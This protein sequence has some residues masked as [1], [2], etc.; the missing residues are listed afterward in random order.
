MRRTGRSTVFVIVLTG[1]WTI[2]HVSG[3][4]EPNVV[5]LGDLKSGKPTIAVT[6]TGPR[7]AWSEK[8]GKKTVML[9]DGIAGDEFDDV[10]PTAEFSRTGHVAYAA[11][12]DKNWIIVIDG[13]EDPLTTNGAGFFRF[14]EDGEHFGY[15]TLE[16]KTYTWN[17]DH[18]PVLPAFA[19]IPRGFVSAFRQIAASPNLDR[20]AFVEFRSNDLR[21]NDAVIS[22]GIGP[23]LETTNRRLSGDFETRAEFIFVCGTKPH[24][25]I[26][27][28][29]MG[30]KGGDKY[31][32]VLDGVAGELA[33]LIHSPRCNKDGSTIG[34]VAMTDR[35][36]VTLVGLINDVGKAAVVINGV[37]G[38]EFR[39]VTPPA[40]SDDGK[41]W[42]Y[43]GVNDKDAVEVIDG[44]LGRE[45]PMAQT[46]K[47][48][49]QFAT[50]DS[51]ANQ[52]AYVLVEAGLFRAGAGGDGIV[53]RSEDLKGAQALSERGTANRR[54]MLNG[55]EI[56]AYTARNVDNL[57][58]TLDGKLAFEVHDGLNSLVGVGGREISIGPYDE[59]MCGSLVV[60]GDGNVQYIARKGKTFYRITQ[61]RPD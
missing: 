5:P 20:L 54:V 4:A 49:A 40:F 11:R 14:S 28:Q 6:T 50:L 29:N 38:P 32:L 1:L 19:M 30:F 61:R 7:I 47:R 23:L 57:Q 25:G 44:T 16:D 21:L 3:Q 39:W 17:V 56:K 43:V 10:L 24:V 2:Q 31:R 26:I 42:A 8:R 15:L 18:K 46:P 22:K 52:L 41:H 37:R 13:K 27:E 45:V 55:K 59:L 36:R 12:K 48:L 34:Y 53:L 33:D 58:F 51:S 60:N 35:L 9:V